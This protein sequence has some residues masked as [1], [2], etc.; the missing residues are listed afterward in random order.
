MAEGIEGRADRRG[1]F[2]HECGDSW[3]MTLVRIPGREGAADLDAVVDR[4]TAAG[5][6]GASRRDVGAELRD[7][8]LPTPSGAWALLVALPGQPW[9]YL[10][11]GDQGASA[12]R[13]RDDLARRAGL[14]V[15]VADHS[16]FMGSVSFSCVEGDETL[17]C[18]ESCG[19]ED[20]EIVEERV[21]G[22]DS[23]ESQTLLRGSRF[24]GEW[25]G[26]FTSAWDAQDA[27]AREFDAFI[28]YMSV[29][30]FQDVV[31]IAAFDDEEFGPD[32][33]LR[34]DLL[35]FG[36]AELEPSAAG[37]RLRDAIEA[38]DADAA[39]AAVAEGASLTTL[40]ARKGSPLRAAL[41]LSGESRLA[42]VAALLELGADPAPPDEEPAVHAL[43]EPL[44]ANQEAELIAV[45]DLLTAHGADVDA[46]GR[47]IMT[48]GATPL[49]AVAR[50]GWLAVAKYLVSKGA[51]AR[52]VDAQGRSP[53]QC[54]E[55]AADS[56]RELG[57]G[58]ADAKYGPMIAFLVA[59][60]AGGDVDLDWRN[61][62]EDAA[63]RDLRR[64]REMKVAFGKIGQGF[65]AL[66]GVSGED[67]S[68]QALADALVYSQPDEIHLIPD[69]DPPDAGP[70]RAEAVALLT[71]EG[72]EPVGRFA[73]PEM[74]KI[75]VEAF[76]H[77]REHMY[78]ALYD[79]AG[80]AFLDLVRYARD[81]SR[82]TVTNNEATAE[83]WLDTPEKRTIHLAGS[84][85]ADLLRAL[86]AEPEPP[87]GVAPAPADEFVARFE[88]AYRR[89]AKARKRRLR[90]DG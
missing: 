66:A 12:D 61:D 79:A 30:G 42:M 63:R 25:L 47:E 70:D 51:D 49:H 36:A 69:D 53:R 10:L 88:D 74:P 9:A 38:G 55:E 29:N 18:F 20:S 16:D 13:L 57:E 52:A 83:V 1:I 81:G 19:L 34:I 8:A 73:I 17:A 67:P 90:R 89:D 59:A 39:R 62:A 86:R 71:A 37:R 28:P 31:E 27:M 14:R 33:F 56:I 77:P 75:R 84:S 64:R 85:P 68:D 35:A 6:V 22:M 2:A 65:K 82:L 40:P 5:V 78:A 32:D 26:R 58:R 44:F 80:R 87:G 3:S 46:R 21:G 60:E 50:R 72:F 11:P 7:G 54:A 43:L 41:G 4:L 23:F 48:M 76:H 24:D 15:V 45:L